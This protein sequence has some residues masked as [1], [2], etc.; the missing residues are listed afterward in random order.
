MV[1][2]LA[3]IAFSA[4]DLRANNHGKVSTFS[5][6]LADADRQHEAQALEEDEATYEVDDAEQLPPPTRSGLQLP[7][8]MLHPKAAERRQ[9]SR[10]NEGRRGKPSSQPRLWSKCDCNC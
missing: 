8:D 1:T 6:L 7:T 2:S 5:E 10:A 3:I 9:Q 4:Q